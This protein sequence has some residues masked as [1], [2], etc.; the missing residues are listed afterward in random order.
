[1]PKTRD[2]TNLFPA[3][4]QETAAKTRADTQGKPTSRFAG[5]EPENSGP[6]ELHHYF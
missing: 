3:N 2:E 5:S 1:M 6:V 4:R